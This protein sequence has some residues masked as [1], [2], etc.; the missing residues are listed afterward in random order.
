VNALPVLLIVCATQAQDAKPQ[1][2]V[3]ISLPDSRAAKAYAASPITGAKVVRASN[4]EGPFF[5][6]PLKPD[7]W[8]SAKHWEVWAT[9]VRAESH[10]GAPDLQARAFL[11]LMALEQQRWDDAW[12]HFSACGASREWMSALLPC[13]CPGVSTNE[14]EVHGPL[15]P[16]L[17]DAVVLRPSLPPPSEHL[18]PG[19]IDARA[20][21]VDG[22]KVGAATLAMSVALEPEGVEIDVEHRGGGAAKLSIVIPA[23][24]DWDIGN[25]YVDWVVQPTHHA[26]LEIAIDA[27][28]PTRTLY[29]RFKPR[30][31]AH[32][33]RVPDAAPAQIENGTLWLVIAP[34]SADAALYEGIAKSLGRL[35]LHLAC[36]VSTSPVPHAVDAEHPC[37]TFVDLRAPD[38]RDEKLAWIVSAIEHVLLAPDKA[39]PK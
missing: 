12:G 20:M 32:P 5:P 7:P 38:T 25:E 24:S 28:D 6:L 29:G 37:A 35:G 16:P 4:G 10:P 33:T 8:H 15:P 3:P 21:K 19:R 13:F 2:P 18:A 39:R 23:P 9:M 34:D 36:A 22:F 31:L 27:S 14:I 17:P 11:A 26:P 30:E 1:A